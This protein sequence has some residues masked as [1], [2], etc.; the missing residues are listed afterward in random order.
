VRKPCCAPWFLHEI[1]LPH[2]R[3]IAAG[4]TACAN[5][6]APRRRQDCKGF[7]SDAR[8]VAEWICC[9][10]CLQIFISRCSK[11][12][13]TIFVLLRRGFGDAPVSWRGAEHGRATCD[14]GGGENDY[15]V[16]LLPG[17][18]YVLFVASGAADG[19]TKF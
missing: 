16:V 2:Y 10:A 11:L 5:L 8:C 4:L 14:G 18:Q 3:G 12:T 6:C 9:H 7:R 19:F 17:G 13:L 1:R 15:S